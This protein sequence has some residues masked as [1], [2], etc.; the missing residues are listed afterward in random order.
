MPDLSWNQEEPSQGFTR[1]TTK[2]R[3]DISEGIRAHGTA[4]QPKKWVET[5]KQPSLE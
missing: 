5:W 3:S 1:Q 2:L 4:K